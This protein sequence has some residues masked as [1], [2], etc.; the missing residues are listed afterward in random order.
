MEFVLQ[1]G[2]VDV[3]RKAGTAGVRARC[4]GAALAG[5]RVWRLSIGRD[6]ERNWE[7]VRELLRS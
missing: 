4:A 6:H 7:A 5:A 3:F 2:M 1:R